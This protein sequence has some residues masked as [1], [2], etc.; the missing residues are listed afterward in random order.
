MNSSAW[1]GNS[2]IFIV[3]DES[4]F[5][6]AGFQ[7]FGDD[8]GCCDAPAGQGGGRVVMLTI[9]HSDHS[10][11]SS[12]VAYN[13]DHSCAYTKTASRTNADARINPEYSFRLTAQ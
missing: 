8:S 2:V 4:D 3:W 5:T 12:S 13:Q 9:S 10:A 11:R 1:T 6:G 7:G